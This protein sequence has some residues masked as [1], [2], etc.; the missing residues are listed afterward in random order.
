MRVEMAIPA[1]TALNCCP[2]LALDTS[3]ESSLHFQV[4]NPQFTTINPKQITQMIQETWVNCS[5]IKVKTSSFL[6]IFIKK[7]IKKAPVTA[8]F[9]ER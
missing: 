9:M 4:S 7:E 2:K 1:K 5:G 6:R 3:L 8:H